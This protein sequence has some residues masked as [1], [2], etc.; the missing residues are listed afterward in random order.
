VPHRDFEWFEQ[1]LSEYGWIN[2]Q[3]LVIDARFAED[4]TEQL[5]TL[6]AELLHA[7]PIARR[8]PRT[9]DVEH[10]QHIGLV[11]A[12]VGAAFPVDQEY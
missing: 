2:G 11:P 12:A 8:V 9:H 1:A 4:R 6:A 3:N 10:G 7:P 5:P